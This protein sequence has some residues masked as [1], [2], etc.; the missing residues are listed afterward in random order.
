[1]TVEVPALQGLL[2]MGQDRLTLKQ[3]LME[4]QISRE[5]AGEV[6]GAV[7]GMGPPRAGASSL[8]PVNRPQGEV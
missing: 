7:G 3:I 8:R 6:E 2:T 5:F 1:M 4:L